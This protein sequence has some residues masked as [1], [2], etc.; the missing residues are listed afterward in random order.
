MINKS[1]LPLFWTLL[2]IFLLMA[3][4]MP[5]TELLDESF[6]FDLAPLLLP[7]FGLLLFVLGLALAVVV[8]TADINGTRKRLLIIAGSAAAG[9]PVS[10][11]L[12]NLVYA[13]L[14]LW[15]GEDFWQRTGMGDEPFFFMMAVLVCPLVYLGGTVGSFVLMVRG[16]HQKPQAV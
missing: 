8:A 12:H 1:V 13:A 5:L 14:V 3:A 10:A 2:G 11:I 7:I 15:F 16:R 4:T 9:I 6:G